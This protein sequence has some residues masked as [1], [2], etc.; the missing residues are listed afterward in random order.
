[1]SYPIQLA[2][3]PKEAYQE[4][5][6]EVIFKGYKWDPQVGDH[7]TVSDCVLL[8]NKETASN[9]EKWAVALSEETINMENALF[10]KLSLANELG[11][12]KK[13]T[14]A[15]PLSKYSDRSS[16]I[17][18]MR[19]D[20][21]PTDTGWM[22][23][24]VNSDVPG[25]FAE[26]SVQ[27]EI[28][29]KY[30][31]GYTHG[32]SA[33][34]RLY[35]AFQAKTG[36]NAKIAFIHA[37]SYSDDRQVMQFLCD[38]FNIRGMEAFPAAPDHLI[39]KGKKAVSIVE[40]AEGLV[41]G[42]VRFYPLEWF[43]NLP[44]GYNWKGYYDTETIS[45]NHPAAILTQSKR[46]P[47][48][49]DRLGVNIPMWKAFLPE[50]VNPELI[51]AFDEEWIYKPAMGRVGEGISIKEVMPE[52]ERTRI[53]KEARKYPKE[54]VAQRRF[55]SMPLSTTERQ[56]YHLCVGVF[57]VDCECAGFY[58]RISPYP[59]ID[60]NAKDTPVLIAKE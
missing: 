10:E 32:T 53:E 4:Y 55:H 60:E 18:V 7:N 31:Q 5:R 19:F 20:F 13:I 46:L 11:L 37:T 3:I 15:L 8:I 43:P 29:E 57:T 56:A 39:W 58:G 16:H 38:Y 9:L 44:M 26:A 41:D 48:V 42:I 51:R 59:R 52:K 21:H 49:W 22:L 47:L 24:E 17:R 28:A 25:G 54:W 14:Q 34:D 12:P 6:Y 27:P 33:A 1:M 36:N 35:K 45:C 50:T 23:S 40:G 2:G 30:F